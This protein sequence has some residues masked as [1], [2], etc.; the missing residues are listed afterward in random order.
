LFDDCHQP[1]LM[2][3]REAKGLPE[4][5]SLV[6]LSKVLLAEHV[7]ALGLPP[8]VAARLLVEL[9]LLVSRVLIEVCEPAAARGVGGCLSPQR[10]EMAARSL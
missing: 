5:L 4:H 8:S 3:L 6:L 2:F 10:P 9:A 7:P 1:I